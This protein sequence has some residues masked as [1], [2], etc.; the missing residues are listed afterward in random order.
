MNLGNDNTQS[1]STTFTRA[2][3]S[4]GTAYNFDLV[5]I[6]FYREFEAA[7]PHL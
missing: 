3:G 7:I 5:H 6:H 1:T 4:E 2:D